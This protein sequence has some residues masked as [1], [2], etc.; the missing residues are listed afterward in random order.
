MAK[1]Y[2]EDRVPTRGLLSQ[3]FEIRSHFQKAFY[4]VPKWSGEKLAS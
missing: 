1:S 2:Y 4:M 3:N